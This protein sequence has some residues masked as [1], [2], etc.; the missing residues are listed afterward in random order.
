[1]SDIVLRAEG[2]TRE[3][4]RPRA[5]W[6]A[7]PPALRAVDGVSLAV[8]R[9]RTLGVVGESG[10]GKSTLARMIVGLLEPT[11]G[12]LE[13]DGQ[14]IPRL[15]RVDRRALH[16]RVQMVFQDPLGSLNPRK[17]VRQILSAPL[18]ALHGLGR[19]ARAARVAELMDLVSLRPDFA[20]RY[21]H[22]FSGGQSQRIGI[23]RALA[24]QPELIVLDEPVSA[25]DVSVQAQVLLLL[26]DLQARLGLTYVFISHDLAV[27][28][29]IAHDVAVMYQGRIVEHAPAERIF[30][31][32]RHDYT[33]LLLSSVP[34]LAARDQ[35][36]SEGLCPS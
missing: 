5:L 9:G 11:A 33:R 30:A 7:R 15:A 22:E 2:V 6:R 24:A 19:A 31:D 26:A 32:P 25:L 16:R 10:C 28:E 20:D 4:T 29:T 34:R 13:I 23:A 8:P 12:T 21:P 17:T 14:S 3:Y 35:I 27:V 18:I 36:V 1:M